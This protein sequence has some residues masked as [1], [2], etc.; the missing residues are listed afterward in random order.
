VGSGEAL[1]TSL[2]QL[3]EEADGAWLLRLTQAVTGTPGAEAELARLYADVSVDERQRFA[4]F[5]GYLI[6]IRRK[7]D[8]SR[9]RELLKRDGPQFAGRPMY[10][11]LS[12]LSDQLG[13]DRV[14]DLKLALTKAERALTR[15]PDNFVVQNQVAEYIAHLAERAPVPETDLIRA[16]SLARDAAY[17][18][19]YP[20]YYQTLA[21]AELACGNYQPAREAIGTAIDLESSAG[22]DYALRIGD[23]NVVRV[24]IDVAE[25]L[26]EV[27]QLHTSAVDELRV[28]RA[29]MVQLLGLLAAAIALISLAGQLTARMEFRDAAPLLATAA[30]AVLC[31]FGGLSY[32]VGG[33]HRYRE[34]LVA[35]VLGVLLLILPASVRA[36]FV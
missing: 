4:A 3:P 26:A 36:V 35:I 16:L 31:I 22:A 8:H 10:L 28:L 17:A 1:L 32:L 5:Y 2:E 29:D 20:R 12:A 24:K 11:C 18:S 34:R 25:S 14:S 23:Y 9:F 6:L 13:S 15:M 33:R 19:G 21:L 7:K 27:R 30:G